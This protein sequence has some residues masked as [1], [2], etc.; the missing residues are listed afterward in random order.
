MALEIKC[1]ASQILYEQPIDTLVA[2]EDLAYGLMRMYEVHRDRD[3]NETMVF[4][5]FD[6]AFSRLQRLAG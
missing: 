1:I 6:E 3:L 5:S 4:R 2:S